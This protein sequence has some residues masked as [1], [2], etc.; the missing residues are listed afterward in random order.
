MSSID[1]VEL[2][3]QLAAT[4]HSDLVRS[5]VDPWMPLVLA[6]AEAARLQVDVEPTA[7]GAT[8]LNG[9]QASFVPSARLIVHQ[10]EGSDFD[11]A[12][13]IAHELG[14][15]HLGDAA[16]EPGHPYAIDPARPAE[17]TPVGLDRVVDYGRRQRRE[18]QMDL[19]AREL[20]LPRYWVKALHLR[21]G[22]TA[23]DI[24]IRLGAPFDVVAQQLLDAL[25][26]PEVPKE[27]AADDTERAL[28]SKQKEAACHEGSHYLLK[29][30]PGTGKTRTLVGRVEHLLG[31]GVDPRRILALT[32]SNKAAG[33][34]SS[35][36][37][38]FDVE[39]AASIWI[40]TFHAFG[41]DI[42][43]RFHQEMGLPADPR[44]LDRVEAVELIENE[45]PRLGLQHYRNLY[46]P[47]D[48]ISEILA[49][50]SRAKDEVVTAEAY[51]ALAEQM[52]DTAA[53]DADAEAANKALEVAKVYALYERIKRER[54]AVDFGDLVCMPVLLLE[55]NE[56]VRNTLRET[57]DYILVDEYQDV[58]RSSVRLLSALCGDRGHVWAVGDAKQSIYRFR[59][60]SS[61]NMER[62]G[63][64]DFLGGVQGQLEENYRS[65]KEVL[66]TMST[67]AKD[68]AV[69]VNETAL[70]P[71]RE[72][73]GKRPELR[74]VQTGDDEIVAVADAVAQMHAD[75][76]AY[77][78]QAVLCT[79]NEKLARFGQAL[80]V[81]GIPVLFLGNL[82]ERSEV[83]D[84]LAFTSLL[85][86]R[87]AMGLLR[88]ACMPQFPMTLADVACV[89]ARTREHD[90]EPGQWREEF[91]EIE[92]LSEGG[93]ASLV[94]LAAV[95]AGFESS[96]NPWTVIATVLLDRTRIAADW[97]QSD[98]IKDRAR[99]IAVWQLMNFLRS[100][101]A[102]RGLPITRVHERIRRLVRLRDDR[103][104]R[105]LPA[106]A[107]HLDA[108]RLMTLHGAKGLEFDVVHLP[109]MN[110]G[111]LPRSLPPLK[112]PPPRGMVEGARPDA[113]E[114][115]RSEHEK[116]QECLFY[117]GLSRARDRLLLYAAS[118]NAAGSKRNL[119][120]YIGRIAGS[121]DA[122]RTQPS[123][124]LPMPAA[125]APVELVV[126]AGMSIQGSEVGLYDSCPRR[127]FYTHILKV[128]GKRTP[129][130]FMQMH[131]AV[132][133]AYTAGIAEGD[134]SDQLLHQLVDE[135]FTG[136]GL[137]EHGYA[138]DYRAL[139][140]D[141]LGFFATSRAGH[142]AEVPAALSLTIDN[143]TLVI[144]PDDVLIAPGGEKLFR[145][146]RTG[147]ARS[148][149]ERDTGNLALLL[150]AR[151]STANA[152]VEVISLADQSVVRIE[153]TPKQL[154]NGRTKVAETLA[155]VRAGVFPS[156]PSSYTC[157]GCPAFFICGP[158]PP[159]PLPKKG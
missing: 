5:G 62:F 14:H 66:D 98:A 146:V 41:L 37:A 133:K 118:V 124:P 127:F 43:R 156:E 52:R 86:D 132:R 150:A 45:F 72:A 16:D 55:G 144:T 32:F 139:A 155:A 95:L 149:D 117:V 20:L 159:G 126:E 4:L 137:A 51:L 22:L 83:R 34:L 125:D 68:M 10:R 12:F 60:A 33:E 76:Y 31:Q 128:G 130:P 109:G 38:R 158:T 8:A 19:F 110:Q 91:D 39:A 3:R 143:E 11:R 135:A 157:P 93:R 63:R 129:T 46:D 18:V 112:C 81:L 2:G 115:H 57:Y 25:L 113:K 145:R 35:R 36:I 15:A 65:V 142:S 9:G 26:L 100:Q 21:D 141:F 111:T 47:T 24:A 53:T 29:A 136:S 105:Q 67:F 107:Q 106:C 48:I 94:K 88:T 79:G 122:P 84:M 152:R 103:D 69:F 121:L 7:K 131:D 44:L 27:D 73:A 140:H 148:G 78:N 6:H 102:G 120:P 104:L 101:P 114:E 82:F 49:A 40:G 80:E 96:S 71:K 59:G 97:S 30:G 54:L 75:G 61:Y 74:Q 138:G 42:V 92:G 151:E 99:G 153:P 85:V 90:L 56:A 23:T 13:L 28:N 64:E 89:I 70:D 58:N 147:H 77:R 119:S 108:V 123:R 1:G 50:V 134:V 154:A 116:E 17:A 87:R